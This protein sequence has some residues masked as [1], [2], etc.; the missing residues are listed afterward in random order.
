MASPR[1]SQPLDGR[2]CRHWLRAI[3]FALLSCC[4]SCTLPPWPPPDSRYILNP[5]RS[6]SIPTALCHGQFNTPCAIEK[7]HQLVYTLAEA[8]AAASDTA[9]FSALVSEVNDKVYNQPF[10]FWPT[11]L[12]STGHVLATGVNG[13][14]SYSGPAYVGGW[15]Q[16]I[17]VHEGRHGSDDP[18]VGG[19]LQYGVWDRI[20]AAAES[21]GYFFTHGW[22]GHHGRE[23]AIATKTVDRVN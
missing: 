17:L 8:F 9:S 1:R 5:E 15:Y 18:N 12:N 20:K 7:V 22:D 10:S 2:T 23:G 19:V 16:D 13:S 14:Q 21:D 4:A 3:S 11:V 6:A